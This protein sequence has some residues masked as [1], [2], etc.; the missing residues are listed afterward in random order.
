MLFECGDEKVEQFDLAIKDGVVVD[1]TGTPAR[2][3]NIGIRGSRIAYIG[4]NRIAGE[5][6]VTLPDDV[7]RGLR[8]HSHVL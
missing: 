8:R 6:T 3:A 2:P 7:S 5:R 4:S 1:G